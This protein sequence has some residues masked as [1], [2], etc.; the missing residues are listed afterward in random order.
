MTEEEQ[1]QALSDLAEM[2]PERDISQGDQRVTFPSAEEVFKRR[3]WVRASGPMSN[4]EGGPI[5]RGS[6]Y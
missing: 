4:L 1:R 5:D 6:E 3:R 2:E